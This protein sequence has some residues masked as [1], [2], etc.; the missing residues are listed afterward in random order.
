MTKT[1]KP[2][3][4]SAFAF[5]RLHGCTVS[6]LRHRHSLYCEH[7]ISDLT[8]KTGR[9]PTTKCTKT[10]CSSNP[11]LPDFTSCSH[12]E[13][14]RALYLSQ[15]STTPRATLPSSSFPPQSPSASNQAIMQSSSIFH[16]TPRYRSLLLRASEIIAGHPS[17]SASIFPPTARSRT[18]QRERHSPSTWQNVSPNT[19]CHTLAVAE[20]VACLN[21]TNMPSF[22]AA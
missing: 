22:V 3:L 13:R 21:E 20:Q 11:C 7:I 9:E 2:A 17:R 12:Q 18:S 6:L 15:P 5:L 10:K 19:Y 14:L 4:R 1:P 16:S 8:A